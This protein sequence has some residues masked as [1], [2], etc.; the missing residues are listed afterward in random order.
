MAVVS[1]L[2]NQVGILTLTTSLNT[3]VDT[4]EKNLR[5]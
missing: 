3:Y 5:R 2:F 4:C 1:I